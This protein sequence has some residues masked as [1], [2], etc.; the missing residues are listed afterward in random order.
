MT[1]AEKQAQKLAD[2]L[3]AKVIQAKG[4]TPVLLNWVVEHKG[5]R[6]FVTMQEW[7]RQG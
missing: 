4:T 5:K 2:A 7:G 1:K 3:V 6:W